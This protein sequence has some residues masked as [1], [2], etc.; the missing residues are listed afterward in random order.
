MRRQVSAQLARQQRI[1]GV[2]GHPADRL[3]STASRITT[4]L[5]VCFSWLKISVRSL[6]EIKFQSVRDMFFCRNGRVRNRPSNAV[7]SDAASTKSCPRTLAASLAQRGS[8]RPR[9]CTSLRCPAPCDFFFFSCPQS[10]HP[11]TRRKTVRLE[12]PW[13]RS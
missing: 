3:S 11:G 13:M 1:Y 8:R 10:G 6:C 9:E 4:F 12:C 5:I 7:C 2:H